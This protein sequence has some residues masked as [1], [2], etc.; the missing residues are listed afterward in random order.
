VVPAQWTAELIGE[1][2][3]KKVTAVR[4]AKEVGWHPKYLSAVLN[5]HKD[6]KDAEEKLRMALLRIEIK[7]ERREKGLSDDLQALAEEY[8]QTDPEYAAEFERSI[9]GHS[10]ST[11]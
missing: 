7:R 5:G 4:L 8:R 2:H 9:L 10:A 1:M 6:P 3:L 11:V